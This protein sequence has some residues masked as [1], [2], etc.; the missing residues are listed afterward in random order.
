MRFFI[1]VYS[2]GQLPIVIMKIGPI[3]EMVRTKSG[4]GAQPPSLAYID[5]HLIWSSGRFFIHV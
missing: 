3:L 2:L 4:V 1:W 5:L